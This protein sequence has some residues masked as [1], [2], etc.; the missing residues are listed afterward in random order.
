M[1]DATG[2]RGA[3][4][5]GAAGRDGPEDGGARAAS[6]DAALDSKKQLGRDYLWNTAA[7]L[8]SS[9]A[10]VIMGIAITRSGSD[11]DSARHA[12]GIFTLAL[13]IGQQYQTLG[14]YEVRTYHVTDVRRRF[15]FGTYLA[16]RILTCALMVAFIVGHAWTRASESSPLLV[17]VCLALLRI[18]DAFEDVYYSEFQ[19]CGRLDIAGRACFL[20]IF[21]TTFLW[22]GLYWATQSLMVA[23]L[24]AFGVTVV[25]LAAAYGLPARGLFPLRPDWGGRAVRGLL[26]QCLP[27]FLAA[28]LNQYL[29]NAPRY[30]VNDFLGSAPLG[31][32]AIIYMPAVAINML[33][34][35]VFRPLLTRIATRWAA[36]DWPGFAAMVRRGLASTAIAFVVV[37]AVTFLVGAP[38]LRLVYG[39]DVSAYRME[40]MVLVFG[41]AMNAAGVILYYALAT[42]RRQ[43]LVLV[44]YALAAVCAWALAQWLTPVLGMMGAAISYSGAMTVLAVLFVLFMVGGRRAVLSGRAAGDGDGPVFPE[45]ED[46]DE[47]AIAEPAAGDSPSSPGCAD[48]NGPSSSGP[49]FAPDAPASD[50]IMEGDPSPAPDAPGAPPSPVAGDNGPCDPRG[51]PRA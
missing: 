43:N 23:T 42:M 11:Q 39:I 13:A 29:A 18:F 38:L 5:P 21:V 49:S 16:T 26:V 32:F 50:T 34:L 1:S 28:F 36:G 44:A 46:G 33:S 37:G 35:F 14:L 40:L 30:A 31:D 17:V 45:P 22:S 8:M 51:G 20:R 6:A 48:Q 2:A 3:G 27:L 47:P 25:V 24:V 12:Y 10:V 4:G 7:S 15:T 41:G 19:R 9:L